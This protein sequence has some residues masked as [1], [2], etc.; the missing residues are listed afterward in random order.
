MNIVITG[1]YC[2][3]PIGGIDEPY[4]VILTRYNRKTFIYPDLD[5]ILPSNNISD[6]IVKVINRTF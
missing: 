6:E 4:M 1:I 2:Q 5:T 3:I